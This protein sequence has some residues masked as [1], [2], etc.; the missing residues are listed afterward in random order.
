MCSH[1]HNLRDDSLICPFDAKH[2]SELLEVVRSRLT[3]RE[4]GVT[5]P[6]HAQRGE[7]LIEEFHAQLAS[8]EWD[9]LNDGQSD[10]PLLILSE[11]HN[12]GE[13]GLREEVDADNLVDK[14]ELGDDVEA[15]VGEFVLEHLEEHGKK[16][17][18]GLLLAKYWGK[19]AD[20]RAKSSTDVLRAVGDQVLDRSHNIVKQGGPV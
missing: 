4:D 7:L 5:Q 2:L 12:S 19:A 13:E 14:F 3:D 20:L 1:G 11:L 17:V 10:A 18:D 8:K 6:G 9:V 16:V 15:D